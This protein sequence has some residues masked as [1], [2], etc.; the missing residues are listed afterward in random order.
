MKKLLCSLLILS[1]NTAVHAGYSSQKVE[2]PRSNL[3]GAAQK[4]VYFVRNK[5]GKFKV[6]L[7]PE[8]VRILESII[9]QHIMWDSDYNI[10]ITSGFIKRVIGSCEVDCPTNTEL[11]RK[12]LNDFKGRPIQEMYSAVGI[13]RNL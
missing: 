10:R 2:E 7:C 12:V 11:V 3:K 1:I 13:S 5:N 4:V 6:E 9:K 8:D